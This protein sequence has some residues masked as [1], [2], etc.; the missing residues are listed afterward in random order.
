MIVVDIET[1]G[2]DHVKCGIWQIGAID[3]LNREEFFQESKIDEEDLISEEALKVIGKTEFQLR[4]ESK[5]SQKELLINF[6]KWVLKRKN[7]IFIAQ[8]PQFDL[9]FLDIKSKK[10]GL[11]LPF[12]YRAFDLHSFAGFKHHQIKGKFLMENKNSGMSL[13]KIIKFC[14]LEDPRKIIDKGKIIKQGESHNALGDARLEAECFSR[15]VLGKG[16]F[17]EYSKFPIPP[18]LRK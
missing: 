3:L 4:E 2:I 5:Q 13:S 7:R 9:A 8:N 16:F 17:K 10:Y 18:E 15:L 6:F 11:K 12:G 14:G 1:S